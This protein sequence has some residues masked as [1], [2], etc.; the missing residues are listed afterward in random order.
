MSPPGAVGRPEQG[1]LCASRPGPSRTPSRGDSWGPKSRLCLQKLS[2]GSFQAKGSRESSLQGGTCWLSGR[3]SAGWGPLRLPLTPAQRARLAPHFERGEQEPELKVLFQAL[4]GL[5]STLLPALGAPSPSGPSPPSPPPAGLWAPPARAASGFLVSGARASRNSAAVKGLDSIL[6]C[7]V[8]QAGAS[9]CTLP[10]A[11]TAQCRPGGWTLVCPMTGTGHL[12]SVSSVANESLADPGWLAWTSSERSGVPCMRASTERG[13]RS[14]DAT[15]DCVCAHVTPDITR[16]DERAQ[17]GPAG[18][19]RGTGR[20][21]ESSSRQGP[22]GGRRDLQSRAGAGTGRLDAAGGPSTCL[23]AQQLPLLFLQTLTFHGRSDAFPGPQ[24]A[25]GGG[26]LRPGC[27]PTPPFPSPAPSPP[28]RLC[29]WAPPR[30]LPTLL[31]EGRT[32]GKQR[33]GDL[34]KAAQLGGVSW[35]GSRSPGR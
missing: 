13:A 2:P 30:G 29:S 19:Q 20:E 8:G 28:S 16:M 9:H 17:G 12:V 34:P 18:P 14:R 32:A 26:E 31:A 7:G 11:L 35:G 27:C 22:C 23:P 5:G 25:V 1:L 4:V 21:G 6:K 33:S 3:H 10:S 24:P 15:H